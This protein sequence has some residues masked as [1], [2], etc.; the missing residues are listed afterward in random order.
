[1][2]SIYRCQWASFGKICCPTTL[3]SMKSIARLIERVMERLAANLTEQKRLLA[4]SSWQPNWQG[5]LQVQRP[6]RWQAYP[7]RSMGYF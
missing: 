3:S 4:V 6:E 2:V 7:A 1:M 5:L